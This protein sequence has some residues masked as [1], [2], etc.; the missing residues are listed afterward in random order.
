MIGGEDPAFEKMTGHGKAGL[1]IMPVA[2]DA[3]KKP[4]KRQHPAGEVAGGPFGDGTTGFRTD[5]GETR[6]FARHGAA[7]EV[8]PEP[9]R[10]EKPKLPPDK[11]LDPP[12]AGILKTHQLK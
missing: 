11:A 12:I 7:F 5:I 4:R 1:E 6:G 3:A 2:G 8:E 9:D 10:P